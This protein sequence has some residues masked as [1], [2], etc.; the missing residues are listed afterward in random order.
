LNEPIFWESV[1]KIKPDILYV[2]ITGFGQTGPDADKAG[3]DA[4]IQAR[5]G[6]R[7]VESAKPISYTEK[8]DESRHLMVGRLVS[9]LLYTSTITLFKNTVP[10]YEVLALYF[11]ISIFEV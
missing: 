9:K 2:S 6:L 4:M 3:Y 1:Q 8:E 5:G 7:N 10:Y 11:F